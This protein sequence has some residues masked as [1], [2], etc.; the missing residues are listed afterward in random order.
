MYFKCINC[1]AEYDIAV[2]N[3]T[4]KAT[5]PE[6]EFCP[7]CGMPCDIPMEAAEA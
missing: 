4:E 3:E 5:E 2:I 6:F 1:K 7:F